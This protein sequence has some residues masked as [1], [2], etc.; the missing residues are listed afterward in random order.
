M[1]DLFA[2]LFCAA[3]VLVVRSQPAQ[4]ESDCHSKGKQVEK[5][6]IEDRI[7]D[8]LFFLPEIKAKNRFIN[9]ITQHKHGITFVTLKKPT[10]ESDYYW[11]Q[12]GYNGALRFEPYYNFYVYYPKMRILIFDPATN[13]P[14]T[15][16]EW[17]KRNRHS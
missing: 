17:R 12:A 9:S 13:T 5:D 6:T 15:L 4:P 11:M 14:Y 8:Q 10:A 1:R 3:S 2:I 7:V 16:S